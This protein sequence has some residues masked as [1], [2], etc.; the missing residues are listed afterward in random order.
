MTPLASRSRVVGERRVDLVLQHVGWSKHQDPARQDRD[1]VAGLRVT[2]DAPSFLPARK[3]PEGRDLY[4]LSPRQSRDHLVQN[5]L[6]EFR[7]PDARKAE[8]KS[9]GMEHRQQ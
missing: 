5:R 1:L 9:K 8:R 6:D 2:T 4:H 3:A 7:R